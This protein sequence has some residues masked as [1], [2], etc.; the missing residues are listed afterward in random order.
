M[1]KISPFI[2][3]DARLLV[4][5]KPNERPDIRPEAIIMLGNV[6][7]YLSLMDVLL[8]YRNELEDT[9]EIDK[10]PFVRNEIGKRFII[11]LDDEAANDGVVLDSGNTIEWILNDGDI[12]NVASSLHGFQYESFNHLHFDP[13][14]K[15]SLFSVCCYL[16]EAG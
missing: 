10:L 8:M 14:A 2:R 1:N 11:K 7:A 4:A 16:E 12:C 3:K 5:K 6:A 9:L 15:E 13:S